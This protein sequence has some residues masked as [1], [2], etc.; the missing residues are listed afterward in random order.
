MR[1]HAK[2]SSA[3]STEGSGN[4][5]GLFRRAFAIRGASGKAGGSGARSIGRRAAAMVAIAA[6]AF[7]SL[8]ISNAF[9][10]QTHLFQ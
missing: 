7:L 2:A 9:A 1:S 3:G 10:L 6:A 8:G 4:A 5:R